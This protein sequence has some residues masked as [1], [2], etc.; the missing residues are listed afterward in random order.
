ME[1]EKDNSLQQ[2]SKDTPGTTVLF[3]LE[4]E[5]EKYSARGSGFFIESD[6]IVTNVHVLAGA[7]KITA[8]RVDP[9]LIFTIEGIVVFDDKYD[10]LQKRII[11]FL[12]GIVT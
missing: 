4:Y 1:N 10:K 2:T 11:H 6:K 5:N 7:T 8:R 3:E 9:E 12:L